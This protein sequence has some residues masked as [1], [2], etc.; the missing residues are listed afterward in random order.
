MTD[1]A[2]AALGPLSAPAVAPRT[3]GLGKDDFLR[4][5]ITQLRHQNPMDPIKQDQFLLQTAQFAALEEL[6]RL[7]RAVEAL[8]AAS[9]AAAQ[10]EVAQLLGRTAKAAG[11][12][13][14][15]DGLTPVRLDFRL[16]GPA[17]VTVEILDGDGQLV[18]R[19]DGGAH[20]A[21]AAGV[22]WDGLDAAGRTYVYR[23]LARGEG[24]Q[25]R[26]AV[27]AEGRVEG[28]QSGDGRPR[29]LLGGARVRPED[30]VEIR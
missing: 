21:G 8:T 13:F 22:A 28:V 27:A 25:A 14:A 19:L 15:F 18:R 6:Q 16:D 29:L 5:L 20:A 10:R 1:G 11:R 12:E 23:V 24:G 30:L 3:P 26:L 17:V 9:A 7:G 2:L 4:L